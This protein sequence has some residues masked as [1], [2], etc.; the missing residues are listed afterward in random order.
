VSFSVSPQV[1]VLA[2]VGIL[3]AVAGGLAV[4]AMGRAGGSSTTAHKVIRPLGHPTAPGATKP[5]VVPATAAKPAV[6][7]AVKPVVV[8]KVVPKPKVSPGVKVA[9]NGLPKPIVHA[10]AHYRVVVVSLYEPN[11]RAT[12][13]QLARAQAGTS[14]GAATGV[15]AIALAEAASGAR[16]AGAGFVGV[17]VLSQGKA[18]PLAALFGVLQDPSVLVFTRVHSKPVNTWTLSAKLAGYADRTT[19]AQAAANSR[20]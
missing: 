3:V 7:A 4:M 11:R 18:K 9:A 2:L 5:K 17:N 10:L 13:L 1:R 14:A 16:D 19:V 8:H 12:A 20:P 6:K 15:D